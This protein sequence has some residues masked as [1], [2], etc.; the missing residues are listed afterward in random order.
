[1]INLPQYAEG[2]DFIKCRGCGLVLEQSSPSRAEW[3]RA[4]VKFIETHDEACKSAY[5]DKGES[6]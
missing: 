6:N 3:Y 5:D 1:M 2:H 4:V